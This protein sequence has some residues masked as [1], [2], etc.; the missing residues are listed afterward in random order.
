MKQSKKFTLIELLVVIAIIAILAA[1]LLPA[2]NS[3]REKAFA[4]RCTGNL[5][6]W[7][8]ACLNYSDIFDDYIVPFNMCKGITPTAGSGITRT[9]FYADSFLSVMIRPYTGS[10]IDTVPIAR[11]PAVRGNEMI[12]DG[13]YPLRQFSY[14]MTREVTFSVN[15]TD[16]YK[17]RKIHEIR[18]PSVIPFLADG[19]GSAQFSVSSDPHINP[20]EI[21]S[22]DGKKRRL[23]YRHRN[24]CMILAFG[25]NTTSTKRMPK[26]ASDDIKDLGVLQ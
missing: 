16:T 24:A 4:I 6:Q 13:T 17:P 9:W 5:K 26:A 14:T 12:F 2:L 22:T 20:A 7:H 21:V 23:D 10:T 15:D 8:V 18:N 25:G 11:C 19:T 3:A 1:L